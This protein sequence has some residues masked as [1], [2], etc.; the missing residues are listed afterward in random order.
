LK[1]ASTRANRSMSRMV[2]ESSTVR[3]VLLMR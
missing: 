1:P 3:M 2:R